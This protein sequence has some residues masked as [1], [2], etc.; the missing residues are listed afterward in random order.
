VGERGRKIGTQ[1]EKEGRRKKG[2][3]EGSG[4]RRKEGP[5]KGGIAL[6]YSLEK[7]YM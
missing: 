2:K 6:F 1:G 7:C 4:E 3:K 5:M